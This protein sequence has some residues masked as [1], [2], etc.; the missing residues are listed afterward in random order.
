MDSDKVLVMDAG[1]AVEFNH[2]Y[3]LLQNTESVFYGLVKETGKTM[4]EHLIEIA[5]KVSMTNNIFYHQ[6]SIKKNK[7]FCKTCSYNYFYFCV[8]VLSRFTQ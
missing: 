5:E 2:P 4:A 3:I 6:N 8:S 1:S 7:F